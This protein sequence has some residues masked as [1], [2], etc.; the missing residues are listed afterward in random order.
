MARKKA[1]ILI[2]AHLSKFASEPIGRF[3][4][5]NPSNRNVKYANELGLY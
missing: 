4:K 3:T 5:L 1:I 2:G